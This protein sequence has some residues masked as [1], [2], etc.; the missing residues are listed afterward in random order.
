MEKFKTRII[1]KTLTMKRVAIAF[2]LLFSCSILLIILFTHL[3]VS[4]KP[5][6]AASVVSKV[7]GKSVPNSINEISLPQDYERITIPKGSF[8]AWLQ[9]IKLRKDNTVYLYNGKPLA[10][11]SLHF[12]VLDF[13]TGNKDLQQCADVIMR[14]RSEYYFSSKAYNKIEFKSGNK[15]YNFQQWLKNTDS[16][17]QDDH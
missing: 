2:C 14:L 1:C 5:A 15:T 8:G 7:S 4:S 11:Q 12:A 17:E 6:V 9:Q 16:P 13:S 3:S 10:D